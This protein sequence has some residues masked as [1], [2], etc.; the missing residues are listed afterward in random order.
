[1]SWL[2]IALDFVAYAGFAVCLPTDTWNEITINKLL[3]H[4]KHATL[5]IARIEP[6]L[7][8]NDG[9]RQLVFGQIPMP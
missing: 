7:R 9:G 2:L 1:M 8:L 6:A 4:F 5:T 3:N